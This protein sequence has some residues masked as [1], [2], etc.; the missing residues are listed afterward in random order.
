[1]RVW[2]QNL[3]F[4]AIV[5]ASLICVA[6]FA[7]FG[8][9]GGTAVSPASTSDAKP[10]N[11]AAAS[12]SLLT[13]T[14]EDAPSFW[15]AALA[16][17]TT[18][19]AGVG[20][21]Q[22]YFLKRSD[23]TTQKSADAALKA[24]LAA[25]R[26]AQVARDTLISSNRAWIQGRL[27]L[28]DQSLSFMNGGLS[29]AVGFNIENTGNAPALNVSFKAWL[30]GHR[31][32]NTISVIDQHRQRCQEARAEQNVGSYCMFPGQTFPESAGYSN[33][34][35]GITMPQ[36]EFEACILPFQPMGDALMLHVGGCV[37]YSFPSDG[38]EIHQTSFLYE[39]SR[40][41][42]PRIIFVAAGDIPGREL[43]LGSLPV[44]DGRYAD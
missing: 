38:G 39:L 8:P 13:K 17:L 2:S 20:L 32:D 30:I 28:S 11:I 5:L 14:V 29:F 21:A 37:N 4:R 33:M 27:I 34:F 25:E 24:A 42:V 18:V 35:I 15:T 41:T 43:S 19:L 7:A 9:E 44:A 12:K 1:M 3:A 26:S 40:T 23:E 22:V 36:E 16:C 31:R 6:A 10:P